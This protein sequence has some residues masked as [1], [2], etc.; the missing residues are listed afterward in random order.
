MVEEGRLT[1]QLREIHP[2]TCKLVVIILSLETLLLFG[3]TV[4]NF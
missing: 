2:E 4:K 3:C 1:P